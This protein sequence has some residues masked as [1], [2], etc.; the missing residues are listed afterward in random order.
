MVTWQTIRFVAGPPTGLVADVEHWRVNPSLNYGW[1]FK[2]A[3]ESPI[4]TARRF[5]SKDHPNA[6]LR[7][8][9]IIDYT[10][11]PEPDTLA[12]AFVAAFA[13]ARYGTRVRTSQPNV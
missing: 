4:R 3:D 5:N 2:V 6:A 8:R 10:V 11:V 7:P 13:L 12:L 1:L 9:L